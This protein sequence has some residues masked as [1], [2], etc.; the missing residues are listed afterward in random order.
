MVREVPAVL[1]PGTVL[2]LLR[3]LADELGRA[4]RGEAW[5]TLRHRL[6][7]TTACHAAIKVNFPL[8]PDKMAYL[9]DQLV[10]TASPMTCPHGRPVV[11]RLTHHELE[12]NF[13]RR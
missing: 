13:G 4:S 6:A 7:A 8:T 3:D 10:L 9:L 11:L 5:E 1:G 12:K 2:P